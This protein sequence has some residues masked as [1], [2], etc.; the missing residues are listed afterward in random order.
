MYVRNE[1]TIV[2]NGG[3]HEMEGGW[4]SYHINI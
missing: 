4:I 3:K 2:G 1:Y